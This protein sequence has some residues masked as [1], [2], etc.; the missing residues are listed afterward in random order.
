[1]SNNEDQRWARPKEL[2]IVKHRL[3]AWILQVSPAQEEKAVEIAEQIISK[4]PK[5]VSRH[6]LSPNAEFKENCLKEYED[7]FK[8][9][10][11]EHFF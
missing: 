4:N 9:N 10:W 8:K 5:T 11:E 7:Y 1:M 3:I 2:A 6:L